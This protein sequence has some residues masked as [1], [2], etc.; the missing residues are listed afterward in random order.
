MGRSISSRSR[1]PRAP[2]RP[3]P[4]FSSSLPFRFVP[5]SGLRAQLASIFD[6]NT[7]KQYPGP[8][9]RES[10]QRASQNFIS[11]QKTPN[12]FP[13][14]RI[15]ASRREFAKTPTEKGD[16]DERAFPSCAPFLLFSFFS[17][18]A[19]LLPLCHSA[20]ISLISYLSSRFIPTKW[21]IGR[22]HV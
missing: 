18:Y 9:S 11:R 1:S 8:R 15:S 19:L 14:R 5:G 21:Q 17:P 12:D 6:S 3:S 16:A 7:L 4:S 13:P 10:F 20:A 22:A 2:R